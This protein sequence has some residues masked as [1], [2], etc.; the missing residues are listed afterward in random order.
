MKKR[1]KS[2][3]NASRKAN[4]A[5]D[6]PA[7]KPIN[8]K[9]IA[10]IAGAVILISIAALC[11]FLSKEKSFSETLEELNVIDQENGMSLHDYDNGVSY[12]KFHPR[13]PKEINLNE[14]EGVIGDLE[15][16]HELFHNLKEDTAA[17]LLVN[18]R[19]ALLDSEQH[20]RLATKTTKGLTADGFKCSERP[21]V[22]EASMNFNIS[23]KQG[24]IAVEALSRM[25][26]EYPEEAKQIDISKFWIKNLNK[27]YDELDDVNQ[28][29]INTIIYFCGKNGKDKTNDTNAIFNMTNA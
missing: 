15:G 20:F 9:I 5:S 1:S 14:Y 6:K 4:K 22:E 13:F 7:S 28:R 18:A 21:Y 23:V 12:L 19:V 10:V 8:K 11:I 3:K 16:V 25:L 24:R 29:N 27:T 2:N 26:D 17:K